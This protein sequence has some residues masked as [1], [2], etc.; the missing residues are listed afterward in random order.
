V[1]YIL[2][3]F[4]WVEYFHPKYNLEKDIKS[5][6]GTSAREYLMT[7][8]IVTHELASVYGSS[9]YSTSD[10]QN[11]LEV[12]RTLSLIENCQH[13]DSVRAGRLRKHLAPRIKHGNNMISWID[14]L[15]ICM[16]A[17]ID[18]NEG[19]GVGDLKV[20]TGDPHFDMI[21]N[22][23]RFGLDSFIASISS[24][25]GCDLRSRIEFL[26]TGKAGDS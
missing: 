14:C 16:C 11:D 6:I 21:A 4:V 8:D 17:R 7:P 2:D 9:G 15:L 5:I 26:Q 12:I 25:V 3:S 23:S 1:K 18:K 19:Q 24:K 20:L 22:P 10:F 13:A